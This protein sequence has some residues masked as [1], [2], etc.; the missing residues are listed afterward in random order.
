[1]DGPVASQVGVSNG[2]LVQVEEG[3]R[4]PPRD[5]VESV[6]EVACSGSLLTVILASGVHPIDHFV[7]G[8]A[9]LVVAPVI[10]S[11]TVHETTKAHGHRTEVVLERGVV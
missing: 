9:G 10:I 6:N 7:N 8:V 5:G 11:S 4:G 1:M 2:V 3:I